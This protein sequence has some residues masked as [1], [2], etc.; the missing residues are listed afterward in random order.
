M[1]LISV[2]RRN[3]RSCNSFWYLGSG[4]LCLYMRC[5]CFLQPDLNRRYWLLSASGSISIILMSSLYFY[6]A[7]SPR[8]LPIKSLTS[9]LKARKI[10]GHLLLKHSHDP[11]A[12]PNCQLVPGKLR[13]LWTRQNM[14]LRFGRWVVII[15]KSPWN[16]GYIKTLKASEEKSTNH[17]RDFISRS[18]KEIDETFN[19][20]KVVQLP[21]QEHW[22]RWLSYIS[23]HFSWKASIVSP[24]NLISFCLSWTF[25]TLPSLSKLKR[26]II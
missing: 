24:V 7:D 18:F 26:Q 5:L 3:Y 8:P 10:S 11:A 19:I 9:V 22:T 21:L 25:D 16:I 1:V 4:D 13:K 12:L 2:E 14:T 23:Q 17:Y 15:T 6:S 20:W